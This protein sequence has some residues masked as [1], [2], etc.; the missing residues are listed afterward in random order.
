MSATHIQMVKW[1]FPAFA[2]VIGLLWYKRHRVDRADPGGINKKNHSDNTI[3]SQKN[4]IAP[5]SFYD[6]DIQTDESLSLNSS[7]QPRD[8][9]VCSPR[10]K[11]ENL[12][13]PQR[14]TGSQCIS[15]HST[16][17]P[18]DDQTWYNFADTTLK[19]E[20]ELGSN[21]KVNN[22]D[23]I[24]KSRSASSLENAA[25]SDDKVL[26]IFENVAEEEEQNL[27]SENKTM[28]VVN[29][30]EEININN[31]CNYLQ[32]KEPSVIS[33]LKD[34]VKTPVQALSERDSAN[35]SPVSGVL[36][37]SVTDE[38]RSEGSTDSGKGGSIKGHIK[39]NIMPMAYEFSIPQNLV[40]RLIGR[41]GSFLQN[42][43][44]KAEV[45]IVVKRHP[46]W[47]DQKIC[48]I[49][50]SM[51]GINIALDLIRQKFPEKKYPHVTLEQIPL[52]IPENIIYTHL[53]E[54][55]LV[56][57]VN[58]DVVICHIVKPNRFFVQLP[59]HPTYPSLRILDEKM[60]QLYNTTES[61]PI[62]DKLNVGMIFVAK[63]Y[64]T[65]VRVLLEQPDPHG[66][67]HLVRLVDH[68]GYWVFSSS[69]LRTIRADYITLPFQAIEVYL[70]NIKP[71]NGE[72]IQEAYDTVAHMCSGIVG[73][74]QI[75]GYVNSYIYVNLYLNIH[76][77]GVISL[78]D[79]L[80]AR[81]FAES[82]I[83]ESI[84]PEQDIL[85]S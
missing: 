67:H 66:E 1:T 12:D 56:E 55:L 42:I 76:K 74:A 79:E 81:G 50:G 35:H 59:T 72:W 19:M 26:K 51:E 75:E 20:I 15:A 14:K 80:I 28:D 83:L 39:N 17:P 53:G 5:S 57:G 85:V 45:Y 69:E 23:M 33:L 4:Q 10:K 41:H 82:V 27:S 63:W 18:K 30:N 49:E 77:Y 3:A 38:A 70:A 7:N 78:A 54:L 37:G 31:D 60:T 71:K 36:E 48:A 52:K 68:G 29:K 64:N 44:H 2:L 13:I 62:P 6:S 61:P 8:E 34:N 40:G 24:A 22:F 21:P 9:I 43:R 58:N 16:T 65:W 73:Q 47:R 32:S 84:V 46:M 25:D 11:S